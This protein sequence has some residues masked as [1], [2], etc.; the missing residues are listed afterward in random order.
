MEQNAPSRE[1]LV[2]IGASDLQNGPMELRLSYNRIDRFHISSLKQF[3]RPVK[4][5]KCGL[6][7]TKV[8]SLYM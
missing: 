3:E 7:W 8:L 2:T 4:G 1:G 6:A 5:V